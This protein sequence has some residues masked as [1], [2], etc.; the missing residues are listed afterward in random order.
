MLSKVLKTPLDPSSLSEEWIGKEI[1]SY[2]RISRVSGMKKFWFLKIRTMSPK[3]LQ[4]IISRVPGTTGAFFQNVKPTTYSSIKYRGIVKKSPK[5]KEYEIHVT[6][7]LHY[8]RFD[9]DDLK[10]TPGM[11]DTMLR[12]LESQRMLD[13]GYQF[14]FYIYPMMRQK[15]R[16]I[17]GEL[18]MLEIRPP[19]TTFSDCEGGGEVFKLVSSIKGFFKKQAYATVSSQVDEETATSRLST[20]TYTL[21]QSFRSDPS[22]TKFH[23]SEYD[24]Y[25]PELVYITLDELMDVE[26]HIIKELLVYALTTKEIKDR[27]EFLKAPLR[28][29]KVWSKSKFERVSYTEAIKI[30]QKAPVKFEEY[31]KWGIDLGK[32]HERYLC[33]HHFEKPTFISLYPSDIKSFYMRQRKPFFDYFFGRILQVC[34][35]V[36]LLVPGIG[37]LCGGSTREYRYEILLSQMK[38]K[39]LKVEDYE[40]YLSLRKQGTIPTGGFGLGFDRFMMF[41]TGSKSIRDV[42]PYPRYYGR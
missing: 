19:L 4:I 6:K 41:L 9:P 42:T 29:L 11:S 16:Q 38:K 2:G 18:G 25:E 35:G 21:A 22:K 34:E 3:D 23:V 10:I 17:S 14:R 39:G 36:D 12:S 33:E 13:K 30:L 24:H 40:E 27:L 5:G 8:G 15:L 32:E 26:E 1:E 31:P 7:I 37:E 28:D 20:H